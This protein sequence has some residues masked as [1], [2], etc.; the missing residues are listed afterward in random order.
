[1]HRHNLLQRRTQTEI[2][3][4]VLEPV[5]SCPSPINCITL[6]ANT[7]FCR[8]FTKLSIVYPTACMCAFDASPGDTKETKYHLPD[9]EGQ[10]ERVCRFLANRNSNIHTATKL[11]FRRERKKTHTQE[12]KIPIT[13]SRSGNVRR[14]RN[15]MPYLGNSGTKYYRCTNYSTAVHIVI[16]WF[17]LYFNVLE[18]Y[19]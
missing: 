13:G 2:F 4:N 3:D 10:D 17:I 7:C 19:P 5:L 1:M 18:I 16:L 8:S 6:E 11:K 15:C 9:T 14:E 12:N